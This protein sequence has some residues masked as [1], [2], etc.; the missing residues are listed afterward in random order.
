MRHFLI[1]LFVLAVGKSWS[2][3]TEKYNSPLAGFYRAEDLFEKE[4]Y[5]ASRKE[6]RVFLDG[7][8]GSKNDPYYIKALYYEGVSALEVY[9]NDAVSLLEQ[10]NRDYPES[11]YK[12]EIFFKI[13]RYYYQK[14]DYKKTIEWLS[15]LNRQNVEQENVDEYYFKLGYAYFDQE[16]YAD[17]K[18]AFYEVKDA[19]SQYGAP[20]LYYYSHISYTD[21][22]YQTAL[23]G[24]EKLLKDPRFGPVV[25]YY[26]TQIYYLQAKYEEVTTFAP[27]KVDSMKPADQ[28]EMNHLIGDSYY[29]LG[30]YDEAVPYLE[31]YNLKA[32][33]TRDDDYELGY[34]YFKSSEYDKAIRYFDKVSR[35]KD[36]LG[37]IALYHAAESY[38][39]LD[40]QAYAR[41]AFEAA[42][43]LDMDLMI[44]ED[45]LYNY[46]ILSYK[47]DL[48]PYDEAVVAL[49]MYLQKYPD[50]PRKNVVYQYL[51]N[52][53]T[54]TKNY[55]KAL[56]SLD[57]LPN[58]DLKLKTAY[59][60]IAFNRGVELY[61]NGDYPGAM[62]A[63][64]LVDKYPVD[65]DVSAKAIF[66]TADALFKLG[67]MPKAIET[68]RAF[69]AMPSTSLSGLRADAYYNIGYA[70][71]AQNN[72]EQVKTS[73]RSYLQEPGSTNKKK[74]ADAHMRLGDAY[75]KGR[76]EQDNREA[77]S[78]YRSA[79]DLRSGYEDQALFFIA[80]LHGFLEERD[81]KIANLQDII[82]NYPNSQYLQSSIYE[83]AVS[84]FND[85]NNDKSLRYFEQIVK[86]YPTS[87]LVKDALH[88]IGDIYFKKKSY[89]QAESYY[90]RVLTEYG[91][92]RE[93]CKREVEAL[94]DIYTAQQ[95]L[96]KV[97]QLADKYPCAD[98][99]RFEV[100]DKF[101]VQSMKPY[102]DSSW[103]GAVIEFDKYLNKY[104]SGKYRNE[105][106]NYKADALYKLKREADAVVIYR[107]TLE[108]P[109]DDFTEVAAQRTAKYLYNSK[110]Y[111]GALP[112]Y[113][114][115]EKVTKS[116]ELI[117][118][119]SLG[120][121]RCHFILENYTNAAE[122]ARK[123]LLNTKNTTTVRLE[124]EFAKGISLAKT[125]RFSEAIS[126]LEYVVKN[127]TN[128]F[129][130]E[131]K[132]TI[133]E[134]YFLAN[135]LVKA[136]AE[137][138]ALLKL[139]PGYNYWIAKALILQTKV[140]I[141][142]NDLFQAE[143]TINSVI[144]NYKVKD[145][146]IIDEATELYDELMQLK[147]EPKSIEEKSGTVIELEEKQGN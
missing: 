21:G 97:E 124:A 58:K 15:Q 14:K 35:V 104:P 67:D 84:Y 143:Q 25:P 136:D 59:Q 98:S 102:Q 96:D 117:F 29:K 27:A 125:D 56:E 40:Q 140:L 138:R 6:F 115:L 100:E 121:M 69:L 34:A 65:K 109:D 132:Y 91:N 47:L 133:A 13:G 2:Q 134:G 45:A 107:Q 48:N 38:L 46:A 119:A 18:S 141:G 20:S 80:R 114:R 9:N 60:V 112:Y 31:A 19:T 55:S 93:T 75:Y 77:I 61:Q 131:A 32:T 83:V 72:N 33:T 86:D 8:K 71:L 76:S 147:N 120:L 62:S 99:I 106:L 135:D 44:Q 103:S 17:A 108:G 43:E 79:Y 23:E 111:E 95:N 139:K 110:D 24:F 30:K 123:V 54:S 116:P 146:G 7:Y 57:K 70:Y 122:Y 142:K 145:D 92:D 53:Y 49:E 39:N 50:S 68:Y 90:N 42:S 66:W 63:F 51:V 126:S 74:K 1:L 41:K 130:S 10:F 28:V 73:F 94:A 78:Q 113:S 36:T 81:K 5:S 82:N 12:Y 137:I 3:A 22:S 144:A 11:I 129:A 118:A 88:Y 101:Y 128:E 52:V 37:Q 64:K 87:I 26:I 85:G 89:S 16:Q 4:Q 105:I 127:T